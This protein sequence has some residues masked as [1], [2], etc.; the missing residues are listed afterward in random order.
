[1]LSEEEKQI[2]QAFPQPFTLHRSHKQP[3]PILFD[4]PHSGRCYPDSFIQASRLDAMTLRRSEDFFVDQLFA[5][6]PKLGANLLCA[7]FPRAFLDVNREPYELDPSLIAGKLPRIA[8]TRSIRVAG[9]LGTIPRV[10]TEG[11]NIYRKKISYAEALARIKQLHLPYHRKLSE[12]LDEAFAAAGFAVLIDCHSMPSLAGSE[13]GGRAVDFVLGD[14]F[15]SSCSAKLTQLVRDKL[16]ELG[17]FVVLNKP[18][19]GGYI[20]EKYGDPKHGV[21]ALQIEIN[22]AL[23]LDEDS[24]RKSR[25]FKKLQADLTELSRSIIETAPVLLAPSRDYRNAAE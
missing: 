9:G 4:S 19:A 17:Y 5:A 2:V 8:N 25:G 12:L 16:T 3:T 23:Y 24:L 15:G 14:R 21:H 7:E 18:Y 6:V 1:M 20:T 11:R 22:R 10:V 13:T